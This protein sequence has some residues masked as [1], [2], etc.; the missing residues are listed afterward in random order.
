MAS[1]VRLQRER[2]VGSK[3][4]AVQPLEREKHFVVLRWVGEG[5]ER[6]QELELEALLTRRVHRVPWRALADRE[7]WVSGWR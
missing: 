1:P 7:H 6:P 3:W 4:T 2:L 5:G